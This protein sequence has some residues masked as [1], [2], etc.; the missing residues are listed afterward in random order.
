MRDLGGDTAVSGGA[1]RYSATLHEGW[2]IWGPQG[3]YVASVALRAAGELTSLRRPASFTCHFLRPAQI[4]N[5]EV[6]VESRRQT[7]RAESL[8]VTCVQND[9]RILEAMVWTVDGVA[10]VDH[11]AAQAPDAP[12]PAAVQPWEN[13]LPGGEQPFPFWSNFDVRPVHPEPEGWA[14][15]GAPRFLTW[16]RL[17]S[18]TDHDDPFVDA[19]RMLVVAD[20]TMFP[21]A[22]LA[23]EGGFPYIAPSLDLTLSFH[24][25]GGA[26]E[27]L[28]VEGL[29][30]LSEGAVVAG[31][32]SI[33]SSD[34]RLLASGQQQMLQR[35]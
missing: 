10:G 33:W 18:P 22:T 7:R 5:V 34:G 15:A 26:S 35:N 29:S 24:R 19:A 2:D 6:R 13:Y 32:A 12:E 9:A 11:D 3:G 23:H 14:R 30:P 21:A 16:M 27:W 4:G 31:A 17:R 25:V 8:R 28:L 20:S 1:G